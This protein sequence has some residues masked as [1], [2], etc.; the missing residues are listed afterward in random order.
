MK[1][2][3]NF[4]Q[5]K[6]LINEGNQYTCQPKDKFELRKILEERLAKDKNANLNDIDVSKIIDMGF[7]ELPDNKGLFQNLDPHNID[8]SKWNV[9]NVENMAAMFYGCKNFNADLS[10]WDVSK[11]TNMY[12]MF[13]YCKKFTGK[14]LE[15]WDVHKVKYMSDMFYYCEIFNANLSKWDISNVE[16]ISYMFTECHKFNCDLNNWDISKVTST[17]SAFSGCDSLKNM[18]SW[19]NG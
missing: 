16:N 19:Y 1:N 10:L 8:I 2:L 17:H 5:E 15:K 13:A 11:V 9:S 12:G 14:G 18:P 6:Y 4:I 3:I 7:D